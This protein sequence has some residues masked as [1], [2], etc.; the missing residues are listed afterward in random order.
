MAERS[1][2]RRLTPD[3][4]REQ[5]VLAAGELFAESAYPSVSV[6]DIARAAGASASLVMFYFTN[7]QALYLEVLSVS[8]QEIRV[9]LLDAPGAPSLER[10]GRVLE[11]YAEYAW[12]HRNGFLSLLRGEHEAVL[13]QAAEI[14]EQ[15]RAD[16]TARIRADL[17]ELGLTAIA[18]D[19][20]ADLA[21]RGYL[22]FVDTVVIRRLSLPAAE[23]AVLGARTIADLGVGVFTG[24]LQALAAGAART[25]GSEPVSS[26]A[27]NS[28]A[29]GPGF[30]HDPAG[31]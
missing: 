7:K 9:G 15:L 19:P 24:C 3:D 27:P 25:S 21:I 14:F 16:V 22:G 12:T 29:P 10:L 30:G 6:A 4:R 31:E 2:R 1:N 20:A 18:Q 13:P 26:V 17:V 28:L 5:I 11:W 8:A 23:A